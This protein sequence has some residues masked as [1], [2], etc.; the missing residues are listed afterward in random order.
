MAKKKRAAIRGAKRSL[1]GPYQIAAARD[2]HGEAVLFIA[3]TSS[4]RCWVT[5]PMIPY[6]KWTEII[7]PPDAG[8]AGD[9]RQTSKFRASR[10]SNA[11]SLVKKSQGRS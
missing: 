10:A 4:G 2:A 11:M 7:E 3:N 6:S 1:P 5:R 9:V 8:E